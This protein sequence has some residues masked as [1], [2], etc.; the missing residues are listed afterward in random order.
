MSKNNRYLT[1]IEKV[2]FNHYSQGLEKFEFER[3]ELPEAAV[4]LGVAVPRNLGD[5]IYSA[6]YRTGLTPAIN[7]TAEEGFIWLLMPAGRGRYAFVH[8]RDFQI[9]PNPEYA[10]TKV[11]EATPG[12]IAMYAQSDEQAL[13]AKIRYNRLIDIFTGITCYSLQS[14]LRT[15]VQGF[16]QVETDEVYVGVDARGI[17][18]VVPVQA[19]TGREK[20]GIVQIM[21][22]V[23]L[24]AGK[25][26]DLV[27]KPIGA[28]FLGADVIV[29]FEFELT[30]TSP[31]IVAEKHY[32]LV[33]PDQLS[34]EE[35]LSY[36]QRMQ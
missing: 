22:D 4:E 2:F 25:F 16:G 8:V 15:T 5:I 7:A 17:Q 36:R 27:T 3:D 11:P 14:H 26:P 19:K 13:L 35:L 32:R 6:R 24:C 30:E 18:Y 34:T 33:H 10:Q 9:T 1:I 12:I 31:R 29:L 21:Q 28:Q 23:V 20:L